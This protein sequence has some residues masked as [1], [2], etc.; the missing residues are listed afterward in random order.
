MNSGIAPT[1]AA[2]LI[3]HTVTAAAGTVAFFCSISPD[4]FRDGN[5][6]FAEHFSNLLKRGFLKGFLFYIDAV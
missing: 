5:R 2:G 6:V 3:V 4:L 1:K